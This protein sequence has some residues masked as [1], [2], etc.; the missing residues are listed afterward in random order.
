MFVE[1][2]PSIINIVELGSITEH[3]FEFR[4]ATYA[5]HAFE[6]RFEHFIAER[7]VAELRATATG[8]A[9]ANNRRNSNLP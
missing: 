2:G 9:S 8:E 1:L 3:R 6:D 7:A 5:R 4:W